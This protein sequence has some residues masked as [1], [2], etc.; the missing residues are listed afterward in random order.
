MMRVEDLEGVTRSPSE[1]G[2]SQRLLLSAREAAETLGIGRSTLYG[3]I[4]ESAI[5]TVQIGRRRLIPT[6]ALG[7]WVKGL[8]NQ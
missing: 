4:G 2:Q 6:A 8:Y 5:P 3:L 1:A 7:D